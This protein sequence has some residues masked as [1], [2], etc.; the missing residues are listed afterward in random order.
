MAIVQLDKVTI[1][2]IA[3]QRES[4]LEGLQRLGCLHLVNLQETA[5]QAA[6]H[7][8]RSE[9]HEALKYLDDCRVKRDPAPARKGFDCRQVTQDALEIK[10]RRR[11]LSDERDEL[12]RKV[13]M[14]EP[15]GDFRLPSNGRLGPL[16][17]WFYTV[18]HHQLD[19]FQKADV[20]WQVV[21]TDNQYV[22][23]V[24]I[25]R[26]Q[27]EGL[28]GSV[29]DLPTLPYSELSA[30]LERVKEELEELHW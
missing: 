23:V 16:Q 10:R 19:G 30:R 20:A 25:S 18:R 2:G 28:P 21:S 12:E 14:L 11:E 3:H 4:V 8:I 15:W 22:Y 1:Y 29:V 26:E 13:A 9:V 7:P 17:F 24:V 27:P 5:P 6:E